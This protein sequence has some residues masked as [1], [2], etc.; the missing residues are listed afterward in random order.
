MPISSVLV[1]ADAI[2]NLSES[3][4]YWAAVNEKFQ[5][6]VERTQPNYTAMQRTGYQRTKNEMAKFLM[7]FSTQRQ[8]NAQIWTASVED[9]LAQYERYGKSNNAEAKAEIKKAN[10]F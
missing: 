1:A 2:S 6:V 3:P 5:R 7:M 10:G 9:M 4:A 8:Q